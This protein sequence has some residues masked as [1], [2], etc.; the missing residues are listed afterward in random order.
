MFQDF[1]EYN[2]K[3]W[4]GSDIE[5]NADRSSNNNKDLI[6]LIIFD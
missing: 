5:T 1:I 3:T 4:N 2:K 6:L